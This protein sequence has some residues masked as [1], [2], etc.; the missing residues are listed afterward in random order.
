MGNTIDAQPGI[1]LFVKSTANKIK[2][3]AREREIKDWTRK[4]KLEFIYLESLK[5]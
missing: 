4:Q 2:A 3:L 1:A 5:L